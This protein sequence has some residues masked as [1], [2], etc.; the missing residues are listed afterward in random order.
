[1]VFLL[2][3]RADVSRDHS[4]GWNSDDKRGMSKISH[5]VGKLDEF[6]GSENYQ[7][8]HRS[9]WAEDTALFYARLALVP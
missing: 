4:S 6:P 3:E 2:C 7:R 1:M 8:V 9:G 5:Q